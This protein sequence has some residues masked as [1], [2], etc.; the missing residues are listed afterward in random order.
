M[1]DFHQ[2]DSRKIVLIFKGNRI[3]GFAPDSFIRIT[4]KEGFTM[5]VGAGSDVTR[6]ASADNSGEVAATLMRSSP[7]NDVLSAIYR[8]DRRSR[9]GVGKLQIEDLLGNLLAISDKA[10]IRMQ[11]EI[12][13]AQEDSDVEWMFDCASL[14]IIAGGSTTE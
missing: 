2:Y 11:P 6:S 5:K 7:S 1:A 4:P 10:W 13:L 9:D 8:S 14:D 3:K 12:E